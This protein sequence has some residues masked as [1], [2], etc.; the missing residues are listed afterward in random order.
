MASKL[1]IEKQRQERVGVVKENNQGDRMYVKIYNS[2]SNIIVQFIDK[3][4]YETKA[5][6]KDFIN[7]LIKNPYH[8]TLYNKGVVGTKYPIQ[9]KLRVPTKEYTAWRTMLSRCFNKVYKSRYP[10]YKDVT[11]CEEW[12]LYENFYEW[13]H[14]Q[15]NFDK[16]LNGEYNVDKDILFKGNKLYSPETCCL[17]PQYINILFIKNDKNRGKNPIGVNYHKRDGK[18]QDNCNYKGKTIYI[19]SYNNAEDAFYLGYKPFKEKIIK[20]IAQEE[21]DKGNIT[22]KCYNAMMN[23]KVEISD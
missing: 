13:I 22:E 4:K 23:Y 15:E 14:A 9:K 17:I 16:W 1:E 18:Y 8:P 20:Q 3:Y 6:W 5:T 7:G 11:C 21:F 19:G 2:S 12:L 10:T